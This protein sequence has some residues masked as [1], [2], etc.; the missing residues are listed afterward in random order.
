MAQ[1]DSKSEKP[2]VDTTGAVTPVPQGEVVTVDRPPP[3]QL[4]IMDVAKAAHLK[5]AFGLQDVKIIALDVD[6]ILV[7]PDDSKIILPG[8]GLAAVSPQPPTLLFSEGT[9]SAQKLITQ[10]GDMKLSDQMSALVLSSSSGQAQSAA[11]AAAKED[12][13]K[14][15]APPPPPPSDGEAA[16]APPP[17]PKAV[18]Q[19]EG[20]TDKKAD[21]DGTS[22]GRGRDVAAD[23]ASAQPASSASAGID[24]EG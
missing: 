10:I 14:P 19:T 7:F 21:N 2:P 24:V 18:S 12:A 13:P 1:A 11:A 23:L 16:P 8:M 6:L 22:N 15:A 20:E 3:G 5:F 17:P 9:I 4:R